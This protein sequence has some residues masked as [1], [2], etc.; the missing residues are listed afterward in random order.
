MVFH[1]TQRTVAEDN[2][3]YRVVCCGRQWGKTTLAVWEMLAC[4]YAKSGRRVAYFATTFDQAR[5][6]A[7]TILKEATRQVWAKE[8]NESRLELTIR[9]QD[10]GTSELFLKGFENIETARG[11]QFDFLVVDEIASMRNW[12]YTWNAILEPTL[13]FRKGK[14]LFISTPKGQNHFKE[15]FELGQQDNPYWKSWRFTSYENPYLPE[16]RIEQAKQTSTEDYFAQEYMAD[17]RKYTGLVYKEFSRETHVKDL[18]GFV[19]VLWLRGLDRGFRNP[20]ALPIV[21]V[22]ADGVWY[23]TSELYE[24]GLTNPALSAKILD[25][26]EDTEFDLSTAD[27]AN[28]GDIQELSDLG[29]DFLPV[30]KQPKEGAQ[31]YVRYKIQKFAERLK[32]QADGRPGY[33]VHP[34][35]TNTIREFETYAWPESINDTKAEPENPLKINDHMMDA[36]GDLNAMYLHTYEPQEKKPWEGKVPG[37]YIPPVE[38]EEE[39]DHGWTSEKH[40]NDWGEEAA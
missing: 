4:A 14:A 21:G 30:S 31:N 9:T 16:E 17:F 15:M 12:D 13:A 8:P 3:D 6:I 22:D 18:P 28:V 38:D 10:G 39:E 37:T 19:P 1:P 23:Q 32:V 36:L 34:Q 2:H 40:E 24:A 11:Q 29:I 7:W 26:T 25:L 33:Y 35:C 20:S 27:S 5:N